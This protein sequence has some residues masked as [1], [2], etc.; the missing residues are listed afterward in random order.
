MLGLGERPAAL[1]QLALGRFD[2]AL[3]LGRC[4]LD[5]FPPRVELLRPLHHRYLDLCGRTFALRESLFSPRKISGRLSK[6]LVCGGL[7]LHLRHDRLLSLRQAR[8]RPVQLIAFLHELGVVGVELRKALVEELLP[9]PQ[10]GLAGVQVERTLSEREGALCDLLIEVELPLRH[11]DVLRLRSRGGDRLARRARRLARLRGRVARG[12]LR[13]Q[14][15]PEAALVAIV[16]ALL[17]LGHQ[18]PPN[19]FPILINAGPRTTM[20]IAGKMKMTVG[21]SILIGAFIAFSSAAA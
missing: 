17:D 21:M 18:N 7:L 12:E 2:G 14:P 20:N 10:L 1:V 16:D 13:A 15:G 3:A 19:S 5:P 9:G 4:P 11:S 8:R 6:R